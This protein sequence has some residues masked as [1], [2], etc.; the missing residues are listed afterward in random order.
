MSES[1]EPAL[2]LPLERANAMIPADLL[3]GDEVIIMLLKPSPLYVVLGCIGTLTI[4]VVIAAI[5]LLAQPWFNLG[6]ST[7]A[8]VLALAAALCGLRLGWQ[9]L[10]WISRTYVLTDRRVIRIKGVL[11]VEVFQ[12]ELKRIQ[13]T[14]VLFSVRERLFGLGTIAFATSGSAYPEAYWIMLRRPMAV[15]RRILQVINRYR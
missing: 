5:L 14:E 6:S 3:F 15:H 13:H 9:S 2:G 4:I 7:R 11:R 12:T 1:P 8:D 10:E